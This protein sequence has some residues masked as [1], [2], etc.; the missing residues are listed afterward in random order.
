MTAGWEVLNED[1]PI[2]THPHRVIRD[3]YWKIISARNFFLIVIWFYCRFDNR[4]Q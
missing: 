4:I 3:S 2:L 1:V